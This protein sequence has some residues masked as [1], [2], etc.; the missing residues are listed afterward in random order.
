MGWLSWLFPSDEDRLR[1]AR[2]RMAAGRWEDARKELVHCQ[3]PEA[4]ALYEECSTHIDKGEAAS[5]KK[6]LA[7]EGFHGWKVEV[8]VKNA[9]LKAELEGLIAEEL[10]RAG[11]DLGMPEIDE[12]ALK[13]AVARAQRRVRSPA[14]EVGAVRLVP[15]ME[16]KFARQMKDA[17]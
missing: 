7:A 9:K 11:V 16:E 3:A 10:A 17:Q 12:K 14:R 4:E 2:A 5:M 6:R 1:R 13:P 8:G 15:I